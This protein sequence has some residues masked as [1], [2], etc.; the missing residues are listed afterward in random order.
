MTTPPTPADAT[1]TEPEAAIVL[2]RDLAAPPSRVWAMWTDAD[3]FASWYG[4]PGATIV[5]RELDPVVGG[6]RHVGMELATP[7]GPMT[8]WF[9]GEHRRVDEPHVLAYTESIANEDGE[10]L[11]PTAMGMPPDHPRVTVVTVELAASDGGTHLVLTHAGV[12][13][14]S[15]GE[16]GWSA[17]LDALAD[18]LAAAT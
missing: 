6:P 7:D 14:G 17:A 5:V 16:Q 11:D 4:P 15:P 9:V 13:A 12:P 1:A 3:R 18:V 2:E 8:M 10:V